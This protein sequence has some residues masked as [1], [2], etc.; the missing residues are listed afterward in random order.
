MKDKAI[1]VKE[2][3]VEMW[4]VVRE[5]WPASGPR[6]EREQTKTFDLKEGLQGLDIE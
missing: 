1:I 5:G 2:W 4:E 3:Q 6:Q